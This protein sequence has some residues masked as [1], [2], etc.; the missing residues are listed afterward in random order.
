VNIQTV[1][2][3]GAAIL[4]P[5]S[6]T[7]V[8]DAQLLLSFVC[9]LSRVELYTEQRDLTAAELTHYRQILAQRSAQAP[10]AYL[11]G[12]KEFWSL[13]LKVTPATLVPRPDTETLVEYVLQHYASAPTKVLELGTGSGAIA[14]ALAKE[15][16]EWSVLATDL[17]TDCIQV[18]QHNADK[19]AIHNVSF[20]CSDWFSGIVARDYDLVVSNPPYVCETCEVSAEVYHEPRQAIFAAE[21]GLRE[22]RTIIESAAGFLKLGGRLVLEHGDKQH[23][24]VQDLLNSAGFINLSTTYDLCGN[25]RV[26]S[27]QKRKFD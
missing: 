10:V 1:L 3:Q 5:A 25:A 19:L 15:R 24:K 17:S 22:I 4:E 7:P 26:T 13:P 18:A 8:L 21:S 14:L 6:D 11:V 12:E 23:R 2:A 27:G 16:P 9:Q 20:L